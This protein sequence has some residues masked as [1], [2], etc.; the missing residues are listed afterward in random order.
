MTAF[1]FLGT[2][3]AIGKTQIA[4]T[5]N[6]TQSPTK[7]EALRPEVGKPLKAAQELLKARKYQHYGKQIHWVEENQ[8]CIYREFVETF[9]FLFYFIL[10]K[11]RSKGYGRKKLLR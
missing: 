7:S 1:S 8:Q 9:L 11:R 3:E 2:S 5:T 4:Q 6:H 10:G